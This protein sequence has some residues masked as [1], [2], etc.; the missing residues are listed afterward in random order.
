MN[1][2]VKLALVTLLNEEDIVSSWGISNISVGNDFLCF[3]VDGFIY[4]GGIR[5]SCNPADYEIIFNGGKI[6]TCQINNLVHIL[7]TNIE[8]TQHYMK[9][10]NEWLSSKNK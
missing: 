5:I 1:A 3:N 8:K 10:L 7:D 9:D 2:K 6:L 4:K